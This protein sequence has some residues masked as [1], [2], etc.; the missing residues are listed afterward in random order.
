MPDNEE[1]FRAFG[2]LKSPRDFGL[3]LGISV[4]LRIST[5]SDPLVFSERLQVLLTVRNQTFW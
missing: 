4:T 5:R 3:C 2:K 1:L